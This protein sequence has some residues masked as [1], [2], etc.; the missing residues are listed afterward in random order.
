MRNELPDHHSLR[1]FLR[2]PFLIAAIAV[3]TVS[4]WL[5]GW[6]YVEQS[7]LHTA[8]EALAMGASDIAAQL[9]RLVFERYADLRVMSTVLA[10][11]MKRDVASVQAYLDRIQSTYEIY[12]WLGVADA[13]GRIIAS[14]SP[15]VIGA[16]VSRAAWFA[17]TR[18]RASSRPDA[19][20][21][22]GIDA[23]VTEKGG[24]D[25]IAFSAAVYD[26][27]GLFQGVVSSR[28]S[29]PMVEEVATETIRSIQAR[30]SALAN[31]E[32]QILDNGGKAAI[33]EFA[34]RG[35]ATETR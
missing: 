35:A 33:E 31:I 34:S 29:I 3:V 30:N 20:V 16:D 6:R 12:H 32:Y 10:K 15:G 4:T 28:V 2:L 8:G 21:L 23:F 17:E 11:D 9:D 1:T 13:D 25:S 14:S 27:R 7:L 26:D 19:M 22:G 18:A 24:P 5:I